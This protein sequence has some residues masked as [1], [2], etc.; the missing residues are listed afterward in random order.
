MFLKVLEGGMFSSKS[1]II[2][3]SKE[4][5]L[6]DTGVHFKN[7]MAILE[8]E[9]LSLKYIIL[10]H[11]HVDHILHMNEL[12]HM[13][14]GS[15]VIHCDDAPILADARLNGTVMCGVDKEMINADILVEDGDSLYIGQTELKF[16]HTPGHTPGSMCIMAENTLFSGDTLFKHS[17]GRT[18]LGAGDFKSL[19]QSLKKLMELPDGIIVY[20]GHGRSTDIGFER[21]NNPYLSEY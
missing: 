17:V 4:A 14:G 13:T 18:D 8:E 21:K 3:D 11:A 1:Y 5:A 12:K 20:P 15:V 16:I 19:E 2:A 7:I 6:I 9:E 10:T